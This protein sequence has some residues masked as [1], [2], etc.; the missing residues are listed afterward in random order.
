MAQRLRTP[1]ALT[2]GPGYTPS[3]H[4]AA[5]SWLSMTSV[6]KDSTASGFFEHHTCMWYAG[7]HDI[8]IGITCVLVTVLYGEDTPWPRQLV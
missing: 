1:A 4:V 6:P 8:R 7:I 2:E 3:T 5:H